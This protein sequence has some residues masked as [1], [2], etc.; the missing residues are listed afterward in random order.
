[1]LELLGDKHSLW[2]NKVK[3][4]GENEFAEDIVQEMY[5]KMYKYTDP[6]KVYIKTINGHE[7]INPNY[8]F[9]VLRNL[10][11]ELTKAKAKTKKVNLED[12]RELP[13]DEMDS[14]ENEY[15]DFLEKM[16][17][18]IKTWGWYESKLF[19]LYKEEYKR[20]TSLRKLAKGTGISWVSIHNTIS[21]CKGELKEKLQGDW[22]KLQKQ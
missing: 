7:A 8:V 10:L 22:D 19:T 12:I 21:R 13:S 15:G 9:F 1:M 11:Y 6:S 17:S 3:A 14:F 20:D 4:L 5:I 18:Q 2:V 16:D